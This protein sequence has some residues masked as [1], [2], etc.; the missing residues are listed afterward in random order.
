MMTPTS[1]AR[2]HYHVPD[3]PRAS[4]R[5][6]SNSHTKAIAVPVREW[7]NCGPK[8][9][10]HSV[11]ETQLM[12]NQDPQEA[13][14]I[15]TPNCGATPPLQRRLSMKVKEKKF[16]GIPLKPPKD[17]VSGVT[18]VCQ[19]GYLF[20]K[21]WKTYA[22]LGFQLLGFYWWR[23]AL[24]VAY[25]CVPSHVSCCSTLPGGLTCRL[26]TAGQKWASVSLLSKI[27]FEGVSVSMYT[28]RM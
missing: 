22:F 23:T 28:W 24:Q 9:L 19:W 1:T 13:D 15:G 8:W 10:I 26:E 6:P 27:G 5:H 14:W 20:L 16:F 2:S 3:S 21:L 18:S 11:G 4:W 7:Q 17:P 25:W 12:R